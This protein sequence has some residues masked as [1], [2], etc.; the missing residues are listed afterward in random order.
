LN[1][2]P[3][4]YQ[5]SAQAIEVQYFWAN[6]MISRTACQKRATIA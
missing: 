1:D 4:H 5:W 2:R 3:F 6:L